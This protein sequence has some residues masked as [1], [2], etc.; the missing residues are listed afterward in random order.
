MLLAS[1]HVGQQP[2]SYMYTCVCFFFFSP[3][4]RHPQYSKEQWEE[5][6]KSVDVSKESM[7]RAI[8]DF[9]ETEGY[10]DAAQEFAKESGTKSKSERDHGELQLQEEESIVDCSALS[11]PINSAHQRR[12]CE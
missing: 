12:V 6:L 2:Y 3:P 7:N 1:L 11:L 5:K 4:P 9:F 10:I 8:M